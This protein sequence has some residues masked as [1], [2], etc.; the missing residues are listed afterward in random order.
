ML[1]LIIFTDGASRGNPGL[2]GAGFIVFDQKN[3]ELN[4]EAF[5]LGEK[6][7]NEAEYFALLRSLAWLKN[8]LVKEKVQEVEWRLDSKL[9]VEQVN[10]RWK[11]KEK[12]LKLLVEKVWQYLASFD[13]TYR[14]IYISREDNQAA[15]QLANQA[16]DRI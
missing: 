2:A 5:F 16:I 3:Q 4:Q 11:I 14:L 1:K 12:R 8:F 9:V 15:D 13:F 10:K 7:N 6:T